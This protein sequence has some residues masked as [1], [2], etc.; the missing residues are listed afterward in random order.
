V[1]TTYQ[2]GVQPPLTGEHVYRHAHRH[3]STGGHPLARPSIF[4]THTVIQKQQAARQAR[5]AQ[6][7]GTT[8]TTG[9]TAT[10]ARSV[11]TTVL[12]EAERKAA[13]E[14]E[15]AEL[16]KFE[17]VRNEVNQLIAS[18]DWNHQEMS[19]VHNLGSQLRQLEIKFWNLK[20]IAEQ[21]VLKGRNKLAE[22]IDLAEEELLH[23]ILVVSQ[24]YRNRV[25]DAAHARFPGKIHPDYL[26]RD[27]HLALRHAQ[28]QQVQRYESPRG[29]ESR[30]YE[31]AYYAPAS[32]GRYARQQ[33]F[34]GHGHPGHFGYDDD[35]SYGAVPYHGHPHQGYGGY[36]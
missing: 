19:H 24:I 35:E 13:K 27:H 17:A 30:G 18:Q 6:T 33:P 5:A 26:Q 28:R 3:H 10:Q 4:D 8:T 7:T 23:A 31:R 15:K 34:L 12:S 25:M 22:R 11:E 1:N 29:Y 36:Y 32:Q 14:E 20:P 16:L 21:L 2:P 9:T